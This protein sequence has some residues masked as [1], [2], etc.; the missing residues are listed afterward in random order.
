MKFEVDDNGKF[1]KDEKNN[2]LPRKR[3]IIGPTSQFWVGKK[4]DFLTA[5][6]IGLRKKFTK[7]AEVIK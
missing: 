3:T 1:V 7:E 4:Q 2:K 6:R 5:L